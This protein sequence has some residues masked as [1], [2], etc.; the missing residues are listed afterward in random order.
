MVARQGRSS[1]RHRFDSRGN[2][3]SQRPHRPRQ[4]G[5]GL[6][7]SSNQS[8]T[9]GGTSDSAGTGQIP[10]ASSRLMR[11]WMGG[12]LANIELERSSNFLIGFAMYR[13][14]VP[15]FAASSTS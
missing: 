5:A 7:L 2:A 3:T 12:W 1:R 4:C 10:S 14:A 11:A 15:R 13:C 9:R 6:N 8:A